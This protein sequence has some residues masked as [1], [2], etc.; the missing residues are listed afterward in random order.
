MSGPAGCFHPM[1]YCTPT[2]LPIPVRGS[3]TCVHVWGFFFYLQNNQTHTYTHKL[4]KHT[5]CQRCR[6]AFSIRNANHMHTSAQHWIDDFAVRTIV[7]QSEKSLP[8]YELEI[9][10]GFGVW[11]C[12]HVVFTLQY[13]SYESTDSSIGRCMATVSDQFSEIMN[14]GIHKS[15]DVIFRGKD[16][17][18][19]HRD[20]YSQDFEAERWFL[21]YYFQKHLECFL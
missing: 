19:L 14:D 18:R 10:I 9:Q 2:S 7:T 16:V 13:T 6:I 17:W 3:D 21:N 15:C 4:V 11:V 5:G 12:V 8:P 1:L 20:Y